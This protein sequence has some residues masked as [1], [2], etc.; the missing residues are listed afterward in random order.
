MNI[1][2]RAITSIFKNLGKTI[3]LLIIIIIL[4]SMIAGAIS[5]RGAIDS[6][7]TNLRNRM[8]PIV[9]ISKNFAA[10]QEYTDENFDWN[11]FDMMTDLP[12]HATMQRLTAPDVRTIGQMEHIAFYDYMIEGHFYSFEFERYFP[13]EIPIQNTWFNSEIPYEPKDFLVRGINSSNMLQIEQNI[14]TLEEGRQ[15]EDHEL[16]P[17]SNDIAVLVSVGF[18]QVNDLSLDSTFELHQLIS[19]PEVGFEVIRADDWFVDENL[20]ERL[21]MTFRIIG[22]FDV[23]IVE[24]LE[25]PTVIEASRMANNYNA[26]YMPNWAIEEFNERWLTSVRSSWASIGED[27]PIFLLTAQGDAVTFNSAVTPIFVLE[28]PRNLEDFKLAVAPNLPDFYE[29]NDLFSAF[30]DISVSMET[31]DDIANWALLASV[32]AT[33]LI[34]SLLITL[35]L[36]DRRH[37]IGIYMALGEKNNKIVIQILCEIMIVSF[38][39]ITISLFIGNI[40]SDQ[41]SR[42]MLET[43]LLDRQNERSNNTWHEHSVF[44]RLGIPQ[45]EMTTEEMMDAFDASLIFR[46]AGLFYLI[47]GGAIILSTLIPVLY[48][49]KLEPKEVLL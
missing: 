8:R 42:S 20:Y 39:A 33:L 48:L 38:V 6:T 27:V 10:F 43:E 7:T 13:E 26:I 25:S 46:T 41:L 29:V 31:M 49:L 32:I 12:P 9:S 40:I 16:T 21:S 22:L 23:P 3:T 4:G 24:N 15:F 11:N 45:I 5:V 34:L 14:I 36:R 47:G 30:D 2:K 18:A 28:D 1:F 17:N 19:P 44:E 35:F 37:E